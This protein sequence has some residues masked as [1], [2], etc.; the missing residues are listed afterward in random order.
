MS[1]FADRSEVSTQVSGT[2][3]LLLRVEGLVVLILSCVA[4]GS[5]GASWL[6]FAAML[7]LPDVAIVGYAVNARAGAIAYNAVHTYL[8]PGVLVMLGVAL[9]TQ[10][11]WP[12]CLIWTAHI[13]MD[14][15][16][17]Y[18]LKYGTAF[19]D[20]HLGRLRRKVA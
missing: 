5:T 15:A 17:G 3:R 12:V 6:L 16:L 18:G 9:G 7:L 19:G 13:G 8:A 2:P 4:Y 1:E 14:R 10:S 20:T 11:I